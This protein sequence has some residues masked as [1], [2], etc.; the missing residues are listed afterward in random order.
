[1]FA[2]EMGHMKNVVIAEFFSPC[3]CD[4]NL[5][6]QFGLFFLKLQVNKKKVRTVRYKLRIV[7]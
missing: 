3:N 1:M 7:T 5:V 4:I 2:P 6:T